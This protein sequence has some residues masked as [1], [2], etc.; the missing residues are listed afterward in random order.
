MV[1]TLA[2]KA[3]VWSSFFSGPAVTDKSERERKRYADD[4][5]YRRRRLASI[6]A[7]KKANRARINAARRLRWAADP[8]LR[9]PSPPVKTSCSSRRSS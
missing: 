9:R 3:R 6:N 2:A 5:E 7:C 8:A 4:P 1:A